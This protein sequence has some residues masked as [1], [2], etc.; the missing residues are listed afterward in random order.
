MLLSLFVSS[1][2]S[3]WWTQSFHCEIKWSNGCIVSHLDSRVFHLSVPKH[4]L[5]FSTNIMLLPFY[6]LMMLLIYRSWVHF[7]MGA[8]IGLIARNATER[9]PWEQPHLLNAA[10]LICTHGSLKRFVQLCGGALRNYG[11][12]MQATIP[13]WSCTAGQMAASA[14]TSMQVLIRRM[15]D[16]SQEY[17]PSCMMNCGHT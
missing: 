10:K 13:G 11:W 17:A 1:P 16:F 4:F 2:R 5:T 14:I 15:A 6:S 8:L 3:F 7:A 9:D 12:N